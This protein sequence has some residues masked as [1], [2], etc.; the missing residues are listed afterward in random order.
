MAFEALGL[1]DRLVQGILATGYTT[2]TE[3]QSRAIP[4]AL[5]GKDIIGSA[6]TGTGKTAAFVLPILHTLAQRETKSQH[7]H[8][9]ILTPTREL[10]QQIEDAILQYGRFMQLRTLAIYGGTSMQNQMKKLHGGVD[11]VI[12]TPGRLLDHLNRKS[13][14]LSEVKVLVLDEADRM[15]DM[16]FIDD[17][18]KIITYTPD[19]RQ[20]MLFSATLSKEIKNLVRNVQKNPE[21]I[22]I[23]EHRSPA[24]SVTQYFYHASEDQKLPLLLHILKTTNLESVLIFSR[25]K[26]GADSLSH[27]LVKAS[28]KAVSIHSDRTQAQRLRA[29]SGFKHGKYN[30]LVATD[31]AARGIDVDGISHVINF[32]IPFYAEDYIHR[33]GRTGRASATG[34]AITFVSRNEI[35]FLK[36]IEHFTKKRYELLRYP[37]FDYKQEIEEAPLH[38]ERRENRRKRS[39]RPQRRDRSSSF[40][41]EGS[42][43]YERREKRNFRENGNRKDDTRSFKRD[44]MRSHE[45]KERR[46]F[47]ENGNRK[48]DSRSF[49]RDGMRSHEQRERRSFGESGNRRDDSHSYSKK[50]PRSTNFREKRTFGGERSGGFQKRNDERSRS[51]GFQ[52]NEKPFFHKEKNVHGFNKFIKKHE[53]SVSSQQ[54]F[55]TINEPDGDWRK[56]MEELRAGAKEKNR[57]VRKMVKRKK[58]REE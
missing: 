44:D 1:N 43:S 26:Q 33:I 12:A 16:G 22:E 47:G 3:I 7:I 49:K 31:V 30:V 25:T 27:K 21:M 42:R 41:R 40:Q 51:R 39:E 18:K 10:A 48:D 8:A 50:E 35:R 5:T 11:I 55:S 4:I 37:D 23:G 20:T 17:V 14:T 19:S 6:H 54:T 24:K 36:K 53:R 52:R 45:Q 13:I 38:E 15:F 57:T 58:H 46:S 9:L 28:I 32:D 34:D 2:P 56:L 29:L